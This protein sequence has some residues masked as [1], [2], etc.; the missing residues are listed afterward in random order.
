MSTG[1]SDTASVEISSRQGV[2][3]VRLTMY[4]RGASSLVPGIGREV[5]AASCMRGCVSR[6][7][8]S[9]VGDTCQP[10][11]LMISYYST[12][13]VRDSNWGILYTTIRSALSDAMCIHIQEMTYKR[14]TLGSITSQAYP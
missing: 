13:E 8:S 1:S 6:T 12:Q 9:S 14:T 5:T 2:E 10:R 3:P 11:T 4:A 7:V